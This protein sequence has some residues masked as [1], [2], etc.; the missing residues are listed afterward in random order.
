MQGGE[1]RGGGGG[2]EKIS[3]LVGNVR[4]YGDS[5]EEGGG[6]VREGKNLDS[7]MVWIK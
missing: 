7:Y 1:H 5:Y 2:R 3:P 6:G 4:E